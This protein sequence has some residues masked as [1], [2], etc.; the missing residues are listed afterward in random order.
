M[1]L[2]DYFDGCPATREMT[3]DQLTFLEVMGPTIDITF[4]DTIREVRDNY[5]TKTRTIFGKGTEDFIKGL[6]ILMY[7]TG[8]KDRPEEPRTIF[9]EVAPVTMVQIPEEYRL[10]YQ[11]LDQL[12][13][14]IDND[15]G[16]MPRALEVAFRYGY[17]MGQKRA[18]ERGPAPEAEASAT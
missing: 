4:S 12:E 9:E 3:I 5:E 16:H 6:D 11:Y 2:Y 17:I 7:M 13:A 10:S 1:T 8:W 14:I 18:A 15:P